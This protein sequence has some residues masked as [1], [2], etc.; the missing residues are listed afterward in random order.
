M[1]VADREKK[2]IDSVAEED[3]YC[4]YIGIPFC[5]TRCLYCSFTSYPIVV[6]KN[7]VDAY[8]D[9]VEK[10]MSYVAEAYSG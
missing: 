4:L 7:K 5:P 2:I 3:E 8:L 1:A 9:A 6:Y 10:E